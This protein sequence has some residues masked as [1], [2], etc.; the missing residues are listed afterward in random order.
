MSFRDSW[1]RGIAA[2]AL[3]AAVTPVVGCKSIMGSIRGVRGPGGGG[4]HEKTLALKFE[5]ANETWPFIAMSARRRGYTV[6]F[7]KNVIFDIDDKSMVE[8]ELEDDNNEIKAEISIDSE[9]TKEGRAERE[10]FAVKLVEEIWAE[11]SAETQT[12]LKNGFRCEGTSELRLAKVLGFEGR[13]DSTFPYIETVSRNRG[14]ATE[15]GADDVTFTYDDATRVEYDIDM[16]GELTMSVLI[17]TLKLSQV[18][19]AGLAD[20]ALAAGQ[21][22]WKEATERTYAA[23]DAAA[24]RRAEDEKAAAAAAGQEKRKQAIKSAIDHLNDALAEADE[25][26][27]CRRGVGK[28]LEDAK[29]QLRDKPSDRVLSRLVDDLSDLLKDADQDCSRKVADAV[30]KARDSLDG[31]T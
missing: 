15:L 19:E 4:D 22:V 1:I 6:N 27:T 11:A 14:Y 2:L 3:A 9:T 24:E 25:D 21:D 26:R 17:E 18:P 10:A 20:K 16:N 29:D 5:P 12:A 23:M 13:A 28:N 31:A 7:G 8:F 30:E